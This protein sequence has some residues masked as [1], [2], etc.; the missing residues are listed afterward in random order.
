MGYTNTGSEQ[1]DYLKLNAKT[2]ETESPFFSLQKK[3]DGKWQ[4]ESTFNQISG[5]LIG[6]SR[7]EGDYQ[8]SPIYSVR[9]RFV[10][11]KDT[12]KVFQ[13]EATYNSLTYTILNSLMSAEKSEPLMIRVYARPSKTYD[14]IYPAAYIEASGNRLEWF[15]PISELPRA[16]EHTVGR[17]TVIDDTEVVEFFHGVVDSLANKY[18]AIAQRATST[19][20]NSDSPQEASAPPPQRQGVGETAKRDAESRQLTA[21]E[22]VEARLEEMRQRAASAPPINTDDDDLPF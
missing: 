9:L 21:D 7:R 1:L 18:G 22:K 15:Y 4:A 19:E 2:S 12:E 11:D 14:K 17:K 6:V 5:Y 20:V 16:I 13:V 8:G 3:I 10:D